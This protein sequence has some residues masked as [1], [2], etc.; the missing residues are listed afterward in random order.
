MQRRR[1]GR[2]LGRISS[3]HQ[4]R[5]DQLVTG[6]SVSPLGPRV[7]IH[8]PRLREYGRPCH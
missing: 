8:G 3:L 1:R 6:S 2:A 4:G 7:V 5:L